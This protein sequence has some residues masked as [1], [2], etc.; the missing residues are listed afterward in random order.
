V[1][2]KSRNVLSIKPIVDRFAKNWKR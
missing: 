1:K 2:G